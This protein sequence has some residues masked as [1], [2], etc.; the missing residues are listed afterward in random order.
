MILRRLK[1]LWRDERG[2]INSTDIVLITTVLILGSIVGLVCLRN[3]IVQE[4]GD[5]ASAVG[6]LNQSYDVLGD[7][8]TIGS[9]TITAVGTISGSSYIDLP[10]GTRLATVISWEVFFGGRTRD[11]VREGGEAILNPTNGASYSGTIVQTQQVASSRLRAIETGLPEA[12]SRLG[13][14]VTVISTDGGRV[15]RTIPRAADGQRGDRPMVEEL[16]ASPHVS[17]FQ[18]D[19]AQ[20]RATL[21]AR[22]RAIRREQLRR[23]LG[24]D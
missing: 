19:V 11:G 13:G 21:D 6:A 22:R 18:L 14:G 3:Q 5:I 4:L 20:Y 2:A 24:R 9:V 7:T 8:A 12:G 1:Q 17:V 15:L 16:A 10:D 23:A